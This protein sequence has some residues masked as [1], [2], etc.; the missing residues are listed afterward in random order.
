MSA[1]PL[2]SVL[3]PVYNGG[4]YLREAIEGVLA[5][6][7]TRF[8]LIV[9]DD[10]STDG[11]VEIAR[12]Y[13]DPRIRVLRNGQNLGLVQTLNRG[14]GVCRSPLVARI[15]SDDVCRRDRLARQLSFLQQNSNVGVCGSWLLIRRAGLPPVRA[16]SAPE[17]WRFPRFDAEIQCTLPFNSPIAHPSV[18]MRLSVLQRLESLYDESFPQAEDYE[19][20]T[21]LS[22]LTRMH[23]LSEPLVEYRLHADS[24]TAGNRGTQQGSARAIR[25]GELRALGQRRS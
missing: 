13:S 23:N 14:I 20:W 25:Q 11:S 12:S 10:G 6:T 8:E 4:R 24:V 9:I 5:Q 16:K 7:L 15:D 19:L 21:R 22:R 2:V 17:L 18:V 3:L 1:S